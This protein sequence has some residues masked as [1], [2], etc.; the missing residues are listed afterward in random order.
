MTAYDSIPGHP[1]CGV[2]SAALDAARSV[3]QDAAAW[4]DVDPD[5]AEAIADAVLAASMPAIRAWCA[6]QAKADTET[7]DMPPE[8]GPGV[9]AVRTVIGSLYLRTSEG[10]RYEEKPD[11]SK[12]DS[13]DFLVRYGCPLTDATAELT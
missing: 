6:D 1:L 2:P 10:W 11:G 8:P 5:Q 7:W 9:R 12:S 13:W 4:K 3:T